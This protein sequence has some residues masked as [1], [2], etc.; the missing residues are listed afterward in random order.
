MASNEVIN[1]EYSSVQ[2]FWN[3]T[4]VSKGIFASIF[5]DEE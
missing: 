5:K 3:T 4:K 2:S 1:N